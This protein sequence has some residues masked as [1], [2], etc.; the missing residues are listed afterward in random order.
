MVH[1]R[2]SS[3]QD[4][5]TCSRMELCRLQRCQVPGSPRSGRQEH[6]GLPETHPQSAGAGLPDGEGG[7]RWHGQPGQL[8]KETPTG[9]NGCS[10][11]PDSPPHHHGFRE[12]AKQPH[13]PLW[14]GEVSCLGVPGRLCGSAPRDHT[15]VTI[16]SAHTT[17]PEQQL[18]APGGHATG[19]LPG[20]L[21]PEPTAGPGG[22]RNLKRYLFT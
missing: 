14:T 4:K 3:H 6:R 10:R 21:A 5:A 8:S 15:D 1:R 9:E 22:P 20:T 7:S 2:A 11:H 16:P 17:G 13:Q 18:R 19:L 12:R